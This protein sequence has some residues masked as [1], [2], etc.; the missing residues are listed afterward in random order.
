MTQMFIGIKIFMNKLLRFALRRGENMVE[1]KT[2]TIEEKNIHL[3][4]EDSPLVLCS[5]KLVL[6]VDEGSLFA[7][8][9]FLNVQPNSINMLTVDV[10]CYNSVRQQIDII[11]NF[12]YGGLDIQRNRD[13]GFNRRIPIKNPETRNIE[14]VIKSIRNSDG[15]IWTNENGSRFDKS[16]EQTSIYSVQ[17]DL[18]KQFTELCARNGINS[19]A[20][21]FQPV[22]ES[23]H[24][25]CACGCFN[26]KS[27]LD[28]FECGT[29]RNWLRQCTDSKYLLKQKEILNSLKP[30][31]EKYDKQHEEEERRKQR[32]EFEKRSR[33]FVE[34]QN[35]QK[36]SQ[37]KKRIIIAVVAAVIAAALIFGIIL[38]GV[39]YFRYASAKSAMSDG[40]YD[41]AITEFTKLEGFLD[42][43]DQRLRAIY[44]KAENV[45][46]LGDKSQ[47][48]E[49]YGSIEGYSDSKEKYNQTQYEIAIMYIEDKEYINAAKIL[50]EL[51]N[52]KDT[53]NMLKQCFENIYKQSAD[54]LKKGNI[55]SAYEG[56]KYL[57]D[58]KDSTDYLNECRYRK[59][60]IMYAKQQY[61]DA[62]KL[63]EVIRGYKDV[64]KILK[65]LD[66]LSLVISIADSDSPAIWSADGML[67]FLC[68]DTDSA[69]YSLAFGADGKYIFKILC[70]NHKSPVRTIE[71]RYKIENNIIYTEKHT[72][73]ISDWEKLL[74]IK[75]I[76]ELEKDVEGKNT[77][78]IVTNPFQREKDITL[79]GNIVSDDSIDFD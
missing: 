67:C 72:N 77:M 74:E 10:I 29:N 9:K 30:N 53:D 66:A 39:P 71:G 17:G 57:G 38:F 19:T 50:E 47:A 51:G 7:F 79:Y 78:M 43:N 54:H 14:I 1:D 68:N 42:S 41:V 55:S 8:A 49:L 69:T 20:L 44:G 48:A 5:M 59:A 76:K 56:F 60:G 6:Y 70:S 18:N 75:A 11:E 35:R 52:Y 4:F 63:Y 34:E 3:W 32:S 22:F 65:K 2:K 46:R 25:M 37:K 64:D 12:V 27:E 73:G 28:C 33:E 40:E 61:A 31:L 36:N 23:G 21:V 15:S 26:L 58:Y 24:W 45:Y 13:F 16:L 62:L